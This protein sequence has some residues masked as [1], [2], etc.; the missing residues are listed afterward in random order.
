VYRGLQ[1]PQLFWKI[2]AW[3]ATMEATPVL[4]AAGFVLDQRPQL[5]DIDLAAV[6]A[7]A[8]GTG[9]LPPLGPYRTFQVPLVDI[10]ELTGLHLAALIEAD[11]LAPLPAIRD[12]NDHRALW[13]ELTDMSNVRV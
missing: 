12:F 7:R 1:I 9:T 3:T 4:R 11:T 8:L 13:T 6:R 10:A 5:A 2:A